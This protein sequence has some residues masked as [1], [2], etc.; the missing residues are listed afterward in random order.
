MFVHAPLVCKFS[1]N[2]AT[3]CKESVYIQ[4]E[5][6]LGKQINVGFSNQDTENES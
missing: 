5:F 6:N 2:K 3:S 1:I 4:T